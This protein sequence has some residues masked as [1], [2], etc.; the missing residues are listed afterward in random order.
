MDVLTLGDEGSYI[1]KILESDYP[2]V[3]DR[4][5]E[6]NFQQQDAS[7]IRG[8]NINRCFEQSVSTLTSNNFIYVV[9]L[10]IWSRLG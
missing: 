9:K 1:S 6:Q 2:V 5:L 8:R 4:V 10:W 7:S 3:Q